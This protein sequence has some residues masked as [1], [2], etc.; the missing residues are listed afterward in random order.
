[1]TTET[2]PAAAGCED[3]AGRWL[4]AEQRVR[5]EP[6]NERLAEAAVRLGEAY[7]DAVGLATQEELRLAWEAARHRQARVE[8]GTPAWADA[9]RIS[10]LLR[11]EYEAAREREAAPDVPSADRRP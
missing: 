2:E 8:I 3:L 6:A 7:D 4:E 9:R 5:T 1:M 11:A 10:E